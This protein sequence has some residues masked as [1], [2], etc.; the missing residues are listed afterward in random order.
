MPD[1]D[2]DHGKPGDGNALRRA[3]P[4]NSHIMSILCIAT[5]A[6][7]QCRMADPIQTHAMDELARKSTGYVAAV[8]PRP[9]GRDR[10][11]ADD[12]AHFAGLLGERPHLGPR[13]LGIEP[14]CLGDVLGT[15]QRLRVIERCLHVL[16][17][18]GERLGSDVLAP[19]RTVAPRSSIELLACSAP[20]TN[21]S[22]PLRA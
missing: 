17:G 21:C 2:A 15:D 12:L 20:E 7:V 16:F 10:G 22:K 1:I 14:H 9:G 3:P 4:S 5:R 19:A 18:P 8:T 6:V 13:I 11:A